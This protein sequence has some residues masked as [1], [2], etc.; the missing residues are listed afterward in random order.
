MTTDSVSVSELA[1]AISGTDELAIVDPRDHE[2]YSQGHLLWA[3]SLRLDDALAAAEVLLPRLSTPIVIAGEEEAE[4]RA[5][6]S[7]LKENGWTNVAVLE[8]GIGSWADA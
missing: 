2:T 3:A 6:Q 1:T 8:G 5:L 7:V 4:A